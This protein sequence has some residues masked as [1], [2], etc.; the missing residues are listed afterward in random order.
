MHRIRLALS[1]RSFHIEFLNPAISRMGAAQF[2]GIA[3]RMF[4]V[5]HIEFYDGDYAPDFLD[6]QY[7]DEQVWG[8]ILNSE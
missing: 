1:S 8:Q 4:G 6:Q 5:G 7:D 3:K 2:P